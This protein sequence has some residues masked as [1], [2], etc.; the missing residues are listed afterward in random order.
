MRTQLSAQYHAHAIAARCAG[1]HQTGRGADNERGHLRHQSVTDGEQRVRAAG[2]RQRHALLH[3]ANK[4]AAQNVH[5]DHEDAE[6]RVALHVLGG[7]VHGA[8]KVGGA[9]DFIATDACFLFVNQTRRQVGVDGHLLAG[10]RVE[11]K[12]RRHFGNTSG[13]LGDDDEIDADEQ[14]EDDNAD[15]VVAADDKLAERLDYAAGVSMGENEACGRDIQ[16]DAK[17]REQ[18]QQRGKAAEVQRIGGVE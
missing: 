17:E 6:N 15:S 9:R 2:F 18:Q 12:T 16:A 14:Q 1:H 10:H 3:N 13:T 11:G 5:G 7:T 8:V 4:D